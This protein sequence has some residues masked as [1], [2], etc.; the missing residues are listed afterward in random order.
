MVLAETE[1]LLVFSTVQIL[2]GDKQ[3]ASILI[4]RINLFQMWPQALRHQVQVDKNKCSVENV[5]EM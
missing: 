5:C 4:A 1:N 3:D 2:Q